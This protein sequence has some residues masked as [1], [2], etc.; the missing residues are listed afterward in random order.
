LILNQVLAIIYEGISF[1]KK[2]LRGRN[3]VKWTWEFSP[4]YSKSMET[5]LQSLDF[6]V[7]DEAER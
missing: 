2:G 4:H 7:I 6:L 1:P 3:E 5:E